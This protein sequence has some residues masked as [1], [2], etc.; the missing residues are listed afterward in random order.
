MRFFRYLLMVAN[1][2]GNAEKANFREIEFLKRHGQLELFLFLAIF[3]FC[4][5]SFFPKNLEHILEA[6]EL[7]K[8]HIFQISCS[9]FYI[10]HDLS[11]HPRV[12]NQ[13]HPFWLSMSSWSDLC[14]VW[15]CKTSVYY[16]LTFAAASSIYKSFSRDSPVYHK[17]LLWRWNKRPQAHVITKT[18]ELCSTLR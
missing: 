17:K 12:I 4:F 16:Y 11:L 18:I 15:C 8:I 9:T 2:F 14:H 3:S 5:S 13:G 6:V 1:G 7:L 10:M